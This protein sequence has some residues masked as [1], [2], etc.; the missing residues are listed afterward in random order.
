MPAYYMLHLCVN[1]TVDDF[2]NAKSSLVSKG[3][4]G[5]HCKVNNVLN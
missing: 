5:L 2:L 4:Q 3:G 1:I